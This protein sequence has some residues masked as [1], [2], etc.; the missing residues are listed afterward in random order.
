VS[1]EIGITGLFGFKVATAVAG[2]LGA[3]VSLEY[4]T[5]LSRWRKGIAILGGAAAASYGAPLLLHFMGLPV[6]LEAGVG[7]FLGLFGMSIA[8]AVFRFLDKVD[9]VGLVK[10]WRK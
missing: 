2:F 4:V 5:D 10:A 8:G 7:F 9:P 3:V 6:S 1:N